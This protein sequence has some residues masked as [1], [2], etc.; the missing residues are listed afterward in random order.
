M[1]PA[2]A[3]CGS[4]QWTVSVDVCDVAG[5][6]TGKSVWSGAQ[7]TLGRFELV[8]ECSTGTLHS[9]IRSSS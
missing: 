5:T 1:V 2:P 7:L 8:G 4:E 3:I 6:G 9:I